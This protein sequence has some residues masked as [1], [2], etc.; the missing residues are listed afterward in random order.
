MNLHMS[1]TTDAFPD[2][3]RSNMGTVKSFLLLYMG[4]KETKFSFLSLAFIEQFFL[5]LPFSFI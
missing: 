2:C 5:A 1:S 4:M 3:Q